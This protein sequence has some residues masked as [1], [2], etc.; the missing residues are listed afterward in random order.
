MVSLV[1]L[2]DVYVWEERGRRIDETATED[3]R[4][5][6]I[7]QVLNVGDG[8]TSSASRSASE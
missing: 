7:R 6:R 3:D 1:E 2:S 8:K 4:E 5:P